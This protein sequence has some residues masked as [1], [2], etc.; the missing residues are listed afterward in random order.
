MKRI[1]GVVALG[2]VAVW[3]VARFVIYDFPNLGDT[4]VYQHAVRMLD[5]GEIPYADFTVEYPPLPLGISWVIFHLPG[6]GLLMF[7]LTMCAALVICAIAAMKL[8]T[9]LTLGRAR[10]LLAVCA[11][12]LVPI[13]LGALVQ[14]RYDLLVAA[15]VALTAVAAASRRFGWMWTWLGVAIALKLVPVV[16]V[17]V[18]VIWHRRHRPARVV[19]RSAGLTA[20]VLIALFAPFVIVA[21]GPTWALFD[22][23]LQR[24]LQIESLGSSLIQALQLPYQQVASFGSENI[25]GDAASIAASLSTVALVAVVIAIGWAAFRVSSQSAS[26]EVVVAAMAATMVATVAL[27]KVLSPQYLT[28]LVPLALVLPGRRGLVAAIAVVAALPLTQLVFPLLY[29]DLVERS[30]G[31]PVTLLLMRNVLLLIALVALWPR[32][33]LN[34]TESDTPLPQDRGRKEAPTGGYHPASP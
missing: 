34:Q 4:R 13:L 18:A 22:Y 14:S 1:S 33:P 17:G 6:P 9:I 32:T 10:M 21:P 11:T 25:V 15:S 3:L 24:P 12:A 27:G 26:P 8:S 23:H 5:A 19:V 31:L 29:P 28:W 20:A 16:L 2:T 7:S 30:A